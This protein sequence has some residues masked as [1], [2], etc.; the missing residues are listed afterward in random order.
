MQ[1]TPKSDTEVTP[2]VEEVKII[3]SLSRNPHEKPKKQW[4]N[5]I[6][7]RY[8]FIKLQ[9][10]STG[11]GDSTE[12]KTKASSMKEVTESLKPEGIAFGRRITNLDQN[13]FYR[14][15]NE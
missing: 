15:L 8:R 1:G 10:Q 5:K 7:I 2:K 6:G 4:Q 12:S 13:P 3:T 14:H 9:R 11:R